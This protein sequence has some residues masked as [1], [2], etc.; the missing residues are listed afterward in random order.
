MVPAEI[1]DTLI[2][3]IEAFGAST[4]E[5]ATHEEIFKAYCAKRNDKHRYYDKRIQRFLED[6]EEF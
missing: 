6:L 2:K 3:F 4:L 1:A 5:E